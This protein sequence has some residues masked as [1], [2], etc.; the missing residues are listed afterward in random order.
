MVIVIDF[1]VYLALLIIG[2]SIISA[3]L[4]DGDGFAF[5]IGIVPFT[6]S[7]IRLALMVQQLF[8]I[9]ITVGGV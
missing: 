6:L 2:G 9:T 1:F 4:H 7:I 3:G 8:H 5:T